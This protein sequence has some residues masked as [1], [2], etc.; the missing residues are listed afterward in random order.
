M[1]PYYQKAGDFTP[2]IKLDPDE[3]VISISGKSIPFDEAD[4]LADVIQWIDQYSE[5]PKSH[6]KVNIELELLNARTMRRLVAMLNHLKSIQDKG[7]R[8][9]VQWRIPEYAEDL[10]ETTADILSAMQLN[11][12]I[13]LN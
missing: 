13:V 2:E 1:K 7:S 11:H 12:R 8:V 10:R 4:F 9:Q 6:T 3:G 5:K